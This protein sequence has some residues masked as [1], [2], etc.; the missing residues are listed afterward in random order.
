MSFLA[1]FI[2]QFKTTG[3]ESLNK[4]RSVIKGV[5]EQSYISLNAM[6]RQ[7]S[8]L[9]KQTLKTSNSI[10]RSFGGLLGTFTRLRGS[11]NMLSFYALTKGL[12][13]FNSEFIEANS[14]LQTNRIVLEELLHSKSTAK[15]FV[16][17]M[18]D[19]SNNYGYS[20]AEVTTSSRSLLEVMNQFGEVSP[21]AL[22]K[23][24]KLGMLLDVMRGE[25][26]GLAYSM[27]AIKEMA[28]GT[29]GQDFKSLAT[30]GSV[31]LHKDD[32][33]KIT[34]L[35][36]KGDVEGF[37]DASVAAFEKIGLSF[38]ILD[39][40]SKEGF[41]QNLNKST[42]YISRIFQELGASVQTHAIPPLL[43]LNEALVSTFQDDKNHK[44]LTDFGESLARSF[45]P[46]FRYL[47]NLGEALSKNTSLSNFL[48][49]LKDIGRNVKAFGGLFSSFLHGLFAGGGSTA[50]TTNENIKKMLSNMELLRLQG[51]KMQGV[52]QKLYQ[53]L[54]EFGTA[55]HNIF[56]EIFKFITGAGG[57]AIV[58]K[59]LIQLATIPL[60]SL[61][62]IA[63]LVNKI[64]GRD[65]ETQKNGGAS[66][67]Q[68][69]IGNG[70]TALMVLSMFRGGKGA[71]IGGAKG[72]AIEKQIEEQ[73]ASRN[74]LNLGYNESRIARSVRD[75][76]LK[77][78]DKKIASAQSSIVKPSNSMEL[79]LHNKN[80]ELFNKKL[81]ES[82]LRKSEA[83]NNPLYSY[84]KK[85]D[86]KN[87]YITRDK[88]EHLRLNEVVRKETE[89]IEKLK[90]NLKQAYSSKE[91]AIAEEMNQERQ[92]RDSINRLNNLKNIRA[93]IE[94][95]LE[96]KKI[97]LGAW[98]KGA[99]FAGE[100]LSSLKNSAVEN[101]PTLTNIALMGSIVFKPLWGQ[102]AKL[103]F[104][105]TPLG[106]AI[107]LVTLGLSY[108][109]TKLQASIQI[110]ENENYMMQQTLES[111]KKKALANDYNKAGIVPDYMK[112][113][114]ETRGWGGKDTGMGL[115]SAIA[116]IYWERKTHKTNL[117]ATQLQHVNQL[118][119]NQEFMQ[120]VGGKSGLE[121]QLGFNTVN[122]AEDK[123]L[124]II[125]EGA[126]KLD[127]KTYNAMAK[128]LA[129]TFSEVIL[130]ETGIKVNSENILKDV[131][132]VMGS[133]TEH[134]I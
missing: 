7:M 86:R 40:L 83:L 19:M 20:M 85:L 3:L 127:E 91:R 6:T 120:K 25:N 55:L 64:T 53:P 131:F 98:E 81:A 37:A 111:H 105:F 76:T 29:G 30:R 117:Y 92:Y 113:I 134:G 35:I 23:M 122:N 38:S 84:N 15:K 71:K 88:A 63:S 82:E 72:K 106:A 48:E 68:E 124:K 24:M 52:F 5:G 109:Y 65:E 101:L 59:P 32:K 96:V 31:S 9:E 77:M 44:I 18:Q 103:T 34:S 42:K 90:N 41:A 60:N 132:K 67:T 94:T 107:S 125:L 70:L 33:K 46:F 16:D 57:L 78:M 87:G 50:N 73:V 80:I 79:A 21:A 110:K 130:D 10:G 27:F 100:K 13:A 133:T 1:R 66:K 43:S 89:N 126:V 116:Q 128:K 97:P 114:S 95:Q 118:M 61:A 17:G 47:T 108:F 119:H 51:I 58:L 39:R 62:T 28:Q 45:D 11:M 115:T 74:A 12:H 121:R 129:Q 93:K 8:A 2:F 54:T 69:W 104:L 56:S 26:R 99:K 14:I 49:N 123:N 22:Q 102:L 36:K 75:N 112:K 4:T